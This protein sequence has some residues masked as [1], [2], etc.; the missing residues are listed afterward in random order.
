VKLGA[1][2]KR[3]NKIFLSHCTITNDGLKHLVT[4]CPI[5]VLDISSCLSIDD[6]GVSMIAQTLANTL[7][8]LDIHGMGHITDTPI[9]LVYDRCLSLRNLGY[10]WCDKLSP[11]LLEKFAQRKVKLSP[12]LKM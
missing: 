4:G 5:A 2:S 11:S 8:T 10:Y 6:E 9:K 12:P 7:R 3:L 1:C